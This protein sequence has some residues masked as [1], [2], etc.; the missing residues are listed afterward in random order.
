[1]S[2]RAKA[3]WIALTVLF[4]VAVAAFVAP[5]VG[6]WLNAQGGKDNA[7]VSTGNTDSA[8]VKMFKD[9]A[10]RL[11]AS[12]A[13][14][15]S[16]TKEISGQ[17]K[18]YTEQ[19]SCTV[20]GGNYAVMQ[21]RDGHVLRQLYEGGQYRFV[22]DTARTVANGIS[23][24]SFPDD[25]LKAAFTGKVIRVKGEILEGK[26]MTCY[27]LYKDGTVYAFYFNQMGALIRYYYI[28]EGSEITIDF[29]RFAIGDA[30]LVSFSVPPAYRQQ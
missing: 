7:P 26:Q 3:V 25:R 20:N 15:F 28:Y 2:K 12:P 19:F 16:G 5:M 4:F 23:S 18:P 9:F 8:E 11:A 29:N 24:I 1:M 14:S 27:E 17:T 13:Y 10:S 6:S 21:T 22:D 30:A